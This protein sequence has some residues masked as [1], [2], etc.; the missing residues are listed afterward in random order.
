MK[1]HVVGSSGTFPTPSNPASG[2]VIESGG[3][4]VWCDAGPGTFSSLPF[5]SDLIDA[6]FL[7][8]RHPDHC[9]DIFTAY[10]AWTFRPD[11]RSGIPLYAN[12]D[13]LDHLAAFAGRGVDDIFDDTFIPHVVESGQTVAEG[14]LEISFIDVSHSVPGIGTRWVGD[15]RTL[16]YSG[17]TG[18]GDW[19]RNLDG[20]N[21][22]L[23][24]AA[25]QGERDDGG[26]IR[27]L[28]AYEAGQIARDAGVDEL[29]LTHIPPYMDVSVS[30]TQAESV[31]GR[32][33]RLA[34]PGTQISV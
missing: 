33:V 23:C 31:F 34:V 6:V 20:V 9:T 14:D 26:E 11:P 8:H 29:V 3:T 12:Q 16:F 30:V 19:A 18:P 7:S 17:D 10:H 15:G 32:P 28:T 1:V 22:F 24:E 21:T 25:L 5:D 13:V 2:Y 27:H 4:K